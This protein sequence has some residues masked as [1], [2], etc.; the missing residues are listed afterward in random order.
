MKRTPFSKIKLKFLRKGK[1]DFDLTGFFSE[2][3][4]LSYNQYCRV[5]T[6]VIKKIE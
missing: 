2:G 4:S 5:V 6:H 3:L 1:V